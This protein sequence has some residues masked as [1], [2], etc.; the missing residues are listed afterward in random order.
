MQMATV[1]SDDKKNK[2]NISIILEC[3]NHDLSITA[4]RVRSVKC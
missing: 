4:G 1:S 2:Q 3:V